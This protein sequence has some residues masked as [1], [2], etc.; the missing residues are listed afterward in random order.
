MRT[1]ATMM[2]LAVG[3]TA[4]ADFNPGT[5]VLWNFNGPSV[6][7]VPGGIASPTP[8]IGLGSASLLGGVSATFASGTASGGSSDPVTTTPSNY[9]WNTTTFAAQGTENNQRGVQ[10]LMSTENWD[11][12]VVQW[13]QRHS[14]TASRY[15]QFLYT[16]DGGATWTN[17]GI[18]GGGVF[19]GDSGDTWFNNRTVDLTN[20]AG[21]ANNANFGFRIVATFDPTGGGYV[22]SNPTSTYA[23]SGT[24]RFDMVEVSGNFIPAPGALALLGLAGLTA[25]RR[26]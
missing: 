26:R 16:L 23:A 4:A 25:R 21:A 2:A 12:I 13:D 14:N 1:I 24:W 15:V 8:V 6:N 20:I 3:A 7:E 22:A 10:F 17:D 11:K 19:V 18:A 5:L 9:G